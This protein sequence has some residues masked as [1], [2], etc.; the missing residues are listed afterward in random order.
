MAEV[1]THSPTPSTPS[2]NPVASASSP[3]PASDTTEASL[4]STPGDSRETP[5]ARHTSTPLTQGQTTVEAET[6]PSSMGS[7]LPSTTTASIDNSATTHPGE[8]ESPTVNQ[9]SR[10][11]NDPSA[12]T[13]HSLPDTS[14]ATPSTP[15]LNISTSANP[16]ATGTCSPI[17]LSIQLENVTSTMIQFSWKPQG[18]TGDSPYTVIL[19]GNSGEMEKKILNGTSIAFKNLLSGHQYQ[20]SVG[21]SSCSKNVSTSLTVQTEQTTSVPP[22]T[23]TSGVTQ[24]T[25]SVPPETNTTGI[26]EQTTS[27]P[28]ETNTS[29]ITEQTTSVPPETNTSGVTEQTT[30]VPLGT[31]TTGITE[32]TTPVPPETNTTGVTQQTSPV[33]PETNTTGVTQQTTSIP[34]ETNTS[35]ITEQTTSVPPETN[36]TGVT[37]QTSPV[38]PET[39][40]TGVTQQTSPVPPETNTTG[41]TG[42]TS[43]SI[44]TTTFPSP[45]CM[46]VSIE[47]Q[48]V[49]GEEI[50]LSWTGGGTGSLYN[51][52]LTDGKQEINK[53]TTKETKAAFKHLLPAHVYTISVGVSSCAENYWAS[54]TVRTDP[55][56]CFN[57]TEFCLPE[58]TPCSDLKGILCSDNQAFA[59]R[60]LL[61]NQTFNNTLYNSDSEEYKAL[62]ESIKTDVVREMR[63]ELKDERFDIT[64][65]GFRP[66]SVV[67]DFISLLPKQELVDANVIQTHLS[68][69]LKRKFGDETELAVQTL[70]VQSPTDNI[71]GWRVAVIVLGVLLGVALLLIL[72]AIIF[73]ICMRKRWGKYFVEPR[74]SWETLSKSTYRMHNVS[75]TSLQ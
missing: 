31:N 70:S 25:T 43:N 57:R 64:V 6:T 53:T 14:L 2:T 42:S 18:G 32:Q 65:L 61:K 37:Q 41:F 21:V 20:I 59:C 56:S 54:V 36:T 51:I 69:I 68:Q 29:G 60:V 23:N 22:E 58:N 30:S 34:P 1:V 63:L 40:T 67:A 44:F 27:V 9:G 3:S 48:N 50:Q 46:P 38:P 24:Q 5:A 33:P 17:T 12:E 66:G 11:T 28:P 73:C 10:T 71:Y 55:V 35:G 74:D 15:N 72:L 26:T 13:S 4:S 39:N 52:S 7:P 47:I 75:F 8:G 49:T 62:A 45:P 19:W 16:S